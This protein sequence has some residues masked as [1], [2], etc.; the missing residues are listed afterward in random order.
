MID[1]KEGDERRIDKL[2]D[3]SRRIHSG[4]I[5][6]GGFVGQ[7]ALDTLAII[8]YDMVG[9]INAGNFLARRS[10]ET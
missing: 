3:Y 2:V 1:Q 4:L 7:E 5:L 8:S 10:L 9:E 6:H